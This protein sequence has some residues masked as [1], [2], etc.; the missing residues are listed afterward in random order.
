MQAIYKLIVWH[1]PVFVTIFAIFL[2]TLFHMFQDNFIQT[3]YKFGCQFAKDVFD[4]FVTTWLCLDEHSFDLDQILWMIAASQ[5]HNNIFYFVQQFS[6]MFFDFIQRLFVGSQKKINSVINL[7][8]VMST[9]LYSIL[10]SSHISNNVPLFS[11][12]SVFDI[13]ARWISKIQTTGLLPH[14]GNISWFSW[15]WFIKVLLFF[16]WKNFGICSLCRQTLQTLLNVLGSGYVALIL[17]N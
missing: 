5:F 13:K 1:Q 16:R 4:N 2:Q 9:P 11:S 14:K 10:K 6:N 17:E 8:L 7:C 3:T 12:I 15:I